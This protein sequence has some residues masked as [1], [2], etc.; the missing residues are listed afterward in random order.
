MRRGTD[1]EVG[2]GP[3]MRNRRQSSL[4]RNLQVLILSRAPV[5][6]RRPAGGAGPPCARAALAG[7]IAFTAEQERVWSGCPSRRMPF[8][9]PRNTAWNKPR[10]ICGIYVWMRR[11]PLP[12]V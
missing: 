4:G 9:Q 6:S 1:E 11:I 10:N 5:E 7:F 8:K 12:E 2:G 3:D